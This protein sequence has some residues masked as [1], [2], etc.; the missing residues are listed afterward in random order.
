MK[1][2][3]SGFFLLFIFNLNLFATNVVS[4]QVPWPIMQNVPATITLNLSDDSLNNS[5]IALTV[6]NT[7]E[8]WQVNGSTA[9]KTI[10]FTAEHELHIK[11]PLLEYRKHVNPIPLW[12][13]IIPPL[14]AILFALLFKEVYISIFFGV[15]SGAF[16]LNYFHNSSFWEGIER[17]FFSTADTYFVNALKDTGHVS[18]VIFSMLIGGMV[19]IVHSNGGM[20]G[21]VN[22]LAKRAKSRRSGQFITW[23]L[24]L[25]IFFD[26][27]A[28]TLV[29][30]NTMR[31]I[32]DQLKISREKLAYIVD[33]TAAPI[34]SIAF[35]T[36][37]IGAEL[38]YIKTGLL[39]IGIDQSAYSVFLSS[40]KYSFYPIFTI[41]FVLLLILMRKDFGPMRYYE[42][43]A[44]KAR[45]N[46]LHSDD[47]IKSSH[48]I[49]GILPV[50]IV[51]VGTLLGLI[52]TGYTS[53]LWQTDA[54]F[55]KRISSII[56]NSD[57][58]IALLWSSL[59]GTVVAIALSVSQ[60]LLSLQKTME[61]LLEGFKSMLPAVIVLVLAWSLA[62]ITSELKTATFISNLLIGFK[63]APWVIPALTFIISAI[64]AF[65]T[66]SSW[67]TMAILFPLVLPATWLICS[68]SGLN[69]EETMAIFSNVVSVVLAGSVMGDH[70]SPISD[71]TIM[72]S[73]ASGC[74]HITHVKTQ[75]PYALTVGG[76]AVLF[77]TLPAALGIPVLP[78]MLLGFASMFFIIRIFG[79]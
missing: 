9:S 38:S 71:T 59:G 50:F 19:S 26:D 37:W 11:T 27:Y 4:V 45:K 57:S 15:F 58:Y 77:G 51:V 8:L 34:A 47:G 18:I 20:K 70:C 72:S 68:N 62:E 63:M 29:V 61:A 60:G 24:G 42:Q 12:L 33:S 23:F 53:E 31:P 7:Q 32:T 14:I 46:T 5:A 67:G 78:L 2:W 44:L 65:S 41:V 43:K 55:L 64:V 69:H 79:K 6:N 17:G 76:I 39:E 21:L 25:F 22:L 13:S 52:I 74:N 16:I 10:I 28:N 3:L 36:T 56:G 49:N 35:V 75:M 40:L 66:G 1:P 48:W 73:L 30:G 54:S